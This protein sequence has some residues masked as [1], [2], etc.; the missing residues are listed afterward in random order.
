MGL[1][2]EAL[3]KNASQTEKTLVNK[4]FSHLNNLSPKV[5]LHQDGFTLNKDIEGEEA[6]KKYLAAYFEKYDYSHETLMYAVNEKT[7]ASFALAYDKDVKLKNKGSLPDEA[8]KAVDTIG[9][10]KQVYGDDGKVKDIYFYRQMSSDEQHTKLK[11]PSKGVDAAKQ[12]VDLVKKFKGEEVTESKLEDAKPEDPKRYDQLLKQA[13]KFSSVW[14][15]GKPELAKSVLSEDVV[16]LD[17]LFGNAIKGYDNWS[18]MVK[19]I[20]E[21][22]ESNNEISDCAV[23][24]CGNKAFIHW[25]NRG[26]ESK[27]GKENNLKGMT[28]LIFGDGDTASHALSFRQPLASERESMM[29]GE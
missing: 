6:V 23:S 1:S 29:K 16:S 17:M 19:G 9:I 22:W 11:D 5:V 21:N 26:K 25:S 24:Y 28:V 8:V 13:E 7:K 2:A 18:K 3:I 27:T 12:T 20:F 15:D 4:D 14:Q 10:W